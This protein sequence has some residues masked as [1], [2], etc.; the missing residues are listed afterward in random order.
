MINQEDLW[1]DNQSR[2]FKNYASLENMK[3]KEPYN[4]G[5]MHLKEGGITDGKEKNESRVFATLP[6]DGTR[7]GLPQS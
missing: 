2:K 7:C 1:D 3:G 5:C 6:W 4:I